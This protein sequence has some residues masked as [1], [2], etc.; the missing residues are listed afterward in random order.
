MPEGAYFKRRIKPRSFIFE[1]Y[2]TRSHATLSKDIW[3]TKN[4]TWLPF[5]W[6]EKMSEDEKALVTFIISKLTRAFAKTKT[7]KGEVEIH[8]VVG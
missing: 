8:V 2:L 1:S 3:I 4:G 7:R 6:W 5:C